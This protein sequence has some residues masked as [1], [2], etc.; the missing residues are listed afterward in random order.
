M[1]SLNRRAVWKALDQP[2]NLVQTRFDID[3]SRC[4]CL[5]QAGDDLVVHAPMVALRYQLE[6]LVDRDGHI[7]RLMEVLTRTGPCNH[8]GA[9]KAFPYPETIKRSDYWKMQAD[10]A[11]V[12]LLGDLVKDHGCPARSSAQGILAGNIDGTGLQV[13]GY[14]GLLDKWAEAYPHK[15]RDRHR[16]GTFTKDDPDW[17]RD[18]QPDEFQAAWGGEI[19]AA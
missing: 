16:L 1:H 15:S 19:I 12:H 3:R 14:D 9:N 4:Q 18:I 7:F 10:G 11:L 13:A 2:A 6:A 5:L 17:W 8:C